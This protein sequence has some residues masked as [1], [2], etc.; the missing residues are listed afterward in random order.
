M[1]NWP[2]PELIGVKGG[3]NKQGAPEIVSINYDMWTLRIALLFKNQS[4]PTYVNFYSIGGFRVLDE[5]NL[6]E[7]WEKNYG[8]YYMYIVKEGG[9][10]AMEASRESAPLLTV[11][12][13]NLT[14][15][16]I[17]GINDCVS[18]LSYS[19]PTISS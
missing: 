5:G 13:S 12:G 17:A 18:I 3:E 6:L 11:D 4:R 19:Q 16:L 10:L 14:E 9:W 15:Y 8:D 7:F 2:I 1:D